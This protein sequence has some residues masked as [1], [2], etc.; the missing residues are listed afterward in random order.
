M[1]HGV[2]TCRLSYRDLHVIFHQILPG[3][4]LFSIIVK[5]ITISFEIENRLLYYLVLNGTERAAASQSDTP[6]YL[7]F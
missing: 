2:N 3:T 4:S 6:T 1:S 5:R 7:Y